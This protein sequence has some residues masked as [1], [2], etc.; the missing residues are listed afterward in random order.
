M[1]F[2]LTLDRRCGVVVCLCHRS[3]LGGWLDGKQVSM[4]FVFT[5]QSLFKHLLT[6]GDKIVLTLASSL[7]NQGVYAVVTNYGTHMPVVTTHAL[8]DAC[9]GVPVQGRWSFA[10]CSNRWKR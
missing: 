8:A 5:Q 6:Q 2:W 1:I 4:A 3:V 9:V 10:S 7:F